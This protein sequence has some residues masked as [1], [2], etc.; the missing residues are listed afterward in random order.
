MYGTK[1]KKQAIVLIKLPALWTINLLLLCAVG[2]TIASPDTKIS[3]AVLDQDDYI[4]TPLDKNGKR[5]PE[6]STRARKGTIYHTGWID[7]NKNG[8]KDVYEDPAATHE[9]RIDDLLSQ[10]NLNEKTCQ[11]C[12]LYGYQRVLRDEVPKTKWKREVWKDGI[13]NIDEQ[14][15]G[16]IKWSKP[17]QTTQFTW[18]A[19]RH[20][21]GINMIQQ[22]FVENTNLGI[23][24]DFTN[25]GIRGIE[26]M[27]ATNLPTQLG[28][29]H[30]WNVNLVRR[31]G[32]MEG[33]EAK[34]LGYSNVYAPILD[35]GRDQRWGRYEEVYGESP[36]L[37]AELGVALTSGIQSQGVA[38]TA[39][40]YCIYSVNKGAREGHA[41]SDPQVSPRETEMIHLMPFKEVIRRADLKGIMSSYND[42]D[43]V[44][45][46]GSSYYLIDKLRKEYGFTGYVVSDSDA[47]RYM[48]NKHH[49]AASYKEAV[50]EFIMAGGNIRTT[51]NHPKNF[52]LP[53]R[54]LVKEGKVPMATIDARVRDVLAVKFWM[55]LFD[56]PYQTDYAKADAEVNSAANN[57][58]ALEA[59]RESIVL[60]KNKDNLLP[61]NASNLKRIL[62][63][64]PNATETKFATMHYGPQDVKVVTTLEGLQTKLKGHTEVLYS[65]GCEIINA[66]WP[67][68]ELIPTPLDS[69]ERTMIAEAVEA[70]KTV[71]VIVAV[72]GGGP[73]ICGEN[74][75]RTSLNLPGRQL[76]LL[77]ALYATGKPLV[78]V[79]ISGRPLSINWTKKY[80]P[81]ILAAWYPGSKGGT[82]IADVLFGDYN[83]GG[84]L[85]VTFPKSVGQIPM[86][87]PAKPAS[88]LD[89][90][91][92][93]ARV[94]G[95]LWPFG[96]G[97]S[98]TTFAYSDLQITPAFAK[99]G[100]PV[101]VSCNVKNSGKRAGDEVVQLYLKDSVSSV[102]TY[103]KQLRGFERVALKPGEVKQVSFTILPKHMQLLNRDMKWVVE[104]GEFRVFVGGDSTRSNLDGKFLQADA[105]KFA[106]LKATGEKHASL[107]KFVHATDSQTTSPP[108]HAIDGDENTRWSSKVKGVYLDV[109]LP[110]PMTISEIEIMWYKPNATRKYNFEI[111]VSSGGGQWTSVAK[112]TTHNPKNKY[113]IYSF[114]A[115]TASAI[116]IVGLGNNEHNYTA[117]N[118]LRI[119]GIKF[120]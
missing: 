88:Q 67:D 45:I 50:G 25:E 83:P 4:Q 82:A 100:T 118:E 2:G 85:T 37:V 41:R 120:D 46:S 16:F 33:R 26:A 52:I 92:K 111:Q 32:E 17:K 55:G 101:T 94:N 7:F 79:M 75:S 93:R 65:K 18:P 53:L 43:G 10:M 74:K 70:A 6:I 96:Y 8:K 105:T 28:M 12:T 11:L 48:Y 107:N 87:F 47:V 49:T 57:V 116:R 44:P 21:W 113:E 97:E 58:I 35:V 81:A 73:S 24:V 63:T 27:R 5:L 114:K 34:L 68:T 42:Y 29:G 59:A 98:Y 102:T 64:G 71:D 108:A 13:G 112:Q 40:H 72:I 60:L 89:A 91:G 14:F 22:W 61:L 84:R 69:T 117:I 54:E 78:V 99:V 9:K 51:F 106:T 39:K 109:E 119:P 115:T 110:S 36:F 15:N 77:Q 80:A 20:A 86:N 3:G 1:F 56:T 66:G 30:T 95:L 23:P 38:S 76:Q 19:S 90:S 62:V 103:D 104:P 31:A